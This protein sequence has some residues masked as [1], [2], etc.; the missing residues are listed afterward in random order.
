[1]QEELEELQA[2]FTRFRSMFDRGILVQTLVAT[3][4]LGKQFTELGMFMQA[5]SEQF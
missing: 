1:M 3:E 5:V 4:N 2:E